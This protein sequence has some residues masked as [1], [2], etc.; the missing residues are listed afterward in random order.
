VR[1]CRPVLRVQ[2]TPKKLKLLWG[3]TFFLS[4]RNFSVELAGKFFFCNY[5]LSPKGG[6]TG[7][8]NMVA[9]RLKWEEQC[10]I[11]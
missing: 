8:K 5:L 11:V 1:L 3:Q 4:G 9:K 10:T 7:F 6:P 2:M